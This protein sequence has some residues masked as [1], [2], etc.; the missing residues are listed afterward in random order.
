MER[1]RFTEES[2]EDLKNGDEVNMADYRLIEAL[3]AGTSDKSGV[4]ADTLEEG[5]LFDIESELKKFEKMLED[6]G[7]VP[8]SDNNDRQEGRSFTEEDVRE[9]ERELKKRLADDGIRNGDSS[10]R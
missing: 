2:P 9:A 7:I 3:H 10:R 8:F 6:E 4:R 5:G 1:L